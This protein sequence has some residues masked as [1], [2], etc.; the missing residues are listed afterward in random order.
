MIGD[1]LSLLDLCQH[2]RLE[3]LGGTGDVAK[4]WDE[5]VQR[6]AEGGP[7][8]DDLA[9][10]GWVFFDGSRWI[11][12]R[13]PLGASSHI[14]YPSPSTKT[15]LTGLGKTRLV[16]KTDTPPPHAKALA[17]RILDENWLDRHIP[18]KDPNWLAGRLWERLCPKPQ[19]H[20][21]DNSGKAIQATT[22]V[23]NEVIL[24]ASPGPD[25]RGA[26]RHPKPQ[27]HNHAIKP[28]LLIEC[29]AL[30]KLLG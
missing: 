6:I 27:L 30:A 15:F 18:A 3:Y 20:V 23:E 24:C 7:T 2:Y 9:R 22:P 14:T 26:V 19:P 28:S 21:A 10:L 5:S 25:T 1:D 17:A 16:A 29:H 11:M 13:T 8:F 12:Q 4:V